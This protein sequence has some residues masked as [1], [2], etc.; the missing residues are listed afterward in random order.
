MN[1]NL[2]YNSALS[3]QFIVT[4]LVAILFCNLSIAWF[5][6]KYPLS[7]SHWDVP[8]FLSRAK[9]FSQGIHVQFYRDYSVEISEALKRGEPDTGFWPFARL[10]TTVLNGSLVSIFG[11][12]ERSIYLIS[13]VYRLLFAIGLLF[14]TLS[15]LE[16]LRTFYPSSSLFAINFGVTISL[17]LY[18]LSDISAYMSGNIVSEVPAIFFL[19]TSIWT[20]IRAWKGQ[21]LFYSCIS[22]ILAFS[23]YSVR[24]ESIWSC[25]AF[26][27]AMIWLF[28]YQPTDKKIWWPGIL[29]VML[30]A[31]VPFLIYSWLFFPLTDPRLFLD[32][33]EVQAERH[34]RLSGDSIH[35]LIGFSKQLIVA[36]GLLFFGFILALPL[37]KANRVFHFGMLW[38]ALLL[39][40]VGFAYAGGYTTQVRMYTTF[41]PAFILL[42]SLGWSYL[43]SSLAQYK[44]FI[45]LSVAVFF[46]VFLVLLSQS[47]SY[48]FL[49]TLPGM[50]R[51]QL[52]HNYLTLPQYERVDY[53]LPELFE[54]RQFLNKI[55]HPFTLLVSPAMQGAD[56]I[57][58]IQFLDQT[59]GKTGPLLFE[60]SGKSIQASR[61]DVYLANGSVA[62]VQYL[63]SQKGDKRIYLIETSKEQSW[64]S[65]LSCCGEFNL[66]LKT[67]HFILLEFI[68]KL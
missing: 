15:A 20:M 11:N 61:T 28:S 27:T 4:V 37:I 50:W 66:A 54:I 34:G 2:Q 21:S 14:A 68:P 56:Y 33:G 67:K 52:I 17:V 26:F 31:G 29:M 12:D 18:L 62:D 65:S 49:R 47:T 41:M 39:V 6:E 64:F 13:W 35:L 57:M 23:V 60:K 48:S 22:G 58:V 55:G 30:G 44:S 1:N 16:I 59:K 5:G 10:G 32:F 8:I 19:S 51:L 24:M 3:Y 43:L 42:S 9:E 45:K 40:P 38:V 53:H 46:I 25:V 7:E 63:K 36:N